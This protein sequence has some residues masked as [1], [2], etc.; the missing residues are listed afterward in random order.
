MIENIN[1]VILKCENIR[2]LTKKERIFGLNLKSWYVIGMTPL[3][4][5]AWISLLNLFTIFITLLLFFYIAEFFDEDISDI[6]FAKI[7]IK[8]P[9]TTYWS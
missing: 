2:E 1:I 8:K 7:V 9:T 3:I 4:L 5:Q 6:F